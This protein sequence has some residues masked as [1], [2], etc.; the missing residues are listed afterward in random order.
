MH[1]KYCD[2]KNKD[3]NKYCSNCGKP[4]HENSDDET[5]VVAGK[6]FYVDKENKDKTE[7]ITNNKYITC[8]SCSTIND[9]S[10]SFCISC[11]K[12]LQKNGL[13][14]DALDKSAVKKRNYECPKCKAL[15]EK[16]SLSCGNCGY[17]LNDK[18][19]TICYSDNLFLKDKIK[20][21]HIV[22]D[23]NKKEILEF[24]QEGNIIIGNSMFPN[25][26]FISESNTKLFIKNNKLILEDLDSKFGTYLKIKEK[27]ELGDNEY[28][29][30]GKTRIKF[31]NF[32]IIENTQDKW[33]E[34]FNSKI[35]SDYSNFIEEN[36]WGKIIQLTKSGRERDIRCISE[37]EFVVG[38]KSLDFSI[39]NDRFLS[40]EHLKIFFH[41]GKAFLID[42]ESKNGTYIRI[43]GEAILENNDY[44]IVGNQLFKVEINL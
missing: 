28:F 44:F 7:T 22:S 10:A 17:Y 23:P 18:T 37:K 2:C 30:I 25:D 24:P 29:L 20:I 5:T 31:E 16:N 6:S 15:I 39:R 43:K 27:K 13:N 26:E 1:C 41:D 33:K 8:K 12:K 32:L 3:S 42:L 4:L 35:Y 38:R 36:Y 14:D 11:G 9:K 34:V 40:N 21:I 19:S